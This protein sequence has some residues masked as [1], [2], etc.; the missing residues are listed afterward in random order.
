MGA[1]VGFALSGA[2]HLALAFVILRIAIGGGGDAEQSRVIASLADKPAG[3]AI[4]WAAVGAWAA[5]SA[6]EAVNALRGHHDTKERLGSAGRALVYGGLAVA[7]GSIVLGGSSDGDQEAEGFAGSLMSV[8]A[9]RVLVGVIGLG[10]VAAA[11][12]YA[13]IGITQRFTSQLKA[14]PAAV[15]YVGTV[16]YPGKGAALAVAGVLFAYAALTA[17]PEKAAGLDGALDSLI[18]APGGPALVGLVGVG[19]GAYG[20]YLLARSRY[21]RM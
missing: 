8:P 2:I 7:A 6:W 18:H 13:F 19:F 12:V 5:L 16:G 21:A 3:A 10:V 14:P 4:V 1:R 9:G 20:L 17:D 11:L 15:R